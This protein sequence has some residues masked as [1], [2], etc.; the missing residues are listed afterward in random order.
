MHPLLSHY[1]WQSVLSQLVRQQKPPQR[2]HLQVLEMS[3]NE[4]AG[5]QISS[6]WSLINILSPRWILHALQLPI[7]Y[8]IHKYVWSEQLQIQVCV[9]RA[10][11]NTCVWG[12]RVGWSKCQRRLVIVSEIVRADIILAVGSWGTKTKSNV[13]SPNQ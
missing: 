12:V 9:E 5:T 8:R 6:F 7:L 2:V 13:I 4:V 1:I 10:I 3:M 11:A